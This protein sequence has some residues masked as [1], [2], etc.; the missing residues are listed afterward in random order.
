MRDRSPAVPTLPRQRPETRLPNPLATHLAAVE[1]NPGSTNLAWSAVVPRR[2]FYDFARRRRTA[3][4]QRSIGWMRPA[5]TLALP[6]DGQKTRC[7]R[8]LPAP[9]RE[10]VG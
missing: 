6:Q 7:A 8:R 9:I 1:W 2:Q 10:F 4:R 3:P 5:R